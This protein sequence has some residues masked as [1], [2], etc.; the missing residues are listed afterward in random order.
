ILS[1]EKRTS[2]AAGGLACAGGTVD[3]VLTVVGSLQSTTDMVAWYTAVKTAMEQLSGVEVKKVKQGKDGCDVVIGM[4]AGHDGS[5]RDLLVRCGSRS[6]SLK[7]DDAAFRGDVIRD[8]MGIIKAEL[9]D[10]TD[11]VR[12]A[13]NI[14]GPHDV[15]TVVREAR[16]RLRSAARRVTDVGNLRKRM[17][18]KGRGGDLTDVKVMA[19]EGCQIDVRMSRDYPK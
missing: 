14:A 17:Q 16:E 13:G 3:S 11:L 15:R 7:V 8:S 10:L 19:C 4:K 5:S 1:N 6:G 18:V 9:P 2:T 12:M